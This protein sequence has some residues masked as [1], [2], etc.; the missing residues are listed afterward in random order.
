[1]FELFKE[2]NWSLL[3]TLALVSA[4]VAWAGD[5]I[6][7]KLGKKRVTFLKL[8]PKYTS[9]IISVVTG[10]GI[11]LFTLLVISVAVEPVRTALF[12]MH[13]VQNQIT[14]LTVEL[15]QNR[16]NL[17]GMEVELFRSKGDVNEKQEELKALEQQLAI[18]TKNLKG[19]RTEL[20]NMTKIKE[21]TEKEQKVLFEE[22]AILEKESKKLETSVASLKSEAEK[23]KADVQRLREGRIAAMT[24]ERLAQGVI[25]GA[26]LTPLQVDQAV[27]RLIGETQAL[28]A[29]RFGT[30]P[31][32]I[33]KPLVDKNSIDRAKSAL[34]KNSGRYLLRLRALSNAVEGEPVMAELETYITKLIFNASSLLAEKNIKK[35]LPRGDLEEIL[36][37]MLRDVN[38]RAAKEGVLRDPLSGNVGSIDTAEFMQALENIMKSKSDS[39]IRIFAAED[40]YTEGPVKIKFEID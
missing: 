37:L 34:S 20:E 11:A 22:K 39:R 30:K 4:L 16:T 24:G 35:G 19:A 40:I 38:A 2:I 23:L 5:I 15:Q 31:D 13:Y 33:K 26:Q 27:E 10:I 36:F 25:S 12:S 8:R 29:Y 14:N 9:R 1:M 18:G 7:M 28:L 21:K 17:Q 6:G 3:G 32:A